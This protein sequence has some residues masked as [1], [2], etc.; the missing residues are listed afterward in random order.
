MQAK[1]KL[2]ALL[3]SL[4]MLLG[5]LPMT[6]FAAGVPAAPTNLKL[7]VTADGLKVSWDKPASTGGLDIFE[8]EVTLYGHFD[9]IAGG[10]TKVETKTV[11]RETTCTFTNTG[12]AEGV[13]NPNYEVEVKA[14]EG[15]SGTG[16][17]DNLGNYQVTDWTDWSNASTVSLDW[18]EVTFNTTINNYYTGVVDVG[19]P[20]SEN[21]LYKEGITATGNPDVTQPDGTTSDSEERAVTEL[22]YQYFEENKQTVPDLENVTVDDLTVEAVLDRFESSQEGDGNSWT[23]TI[24]ATVNRY[25]TLRLVYNPEADSNNPDEKQ[26]VNAVNLVNVSISMEMGLTPAFTAEVDSSDQDKY[27]VYL[28]QWIGSDG[29]SITSE[30]SFNSE[31]SEDE[32][33]TTFE[34]G[35]TYRYSVWVKAKEGYAISEEAS[36]YLNGRPANKGYTLTNHDEPKRPD[37]SFLSGTFNSLFVME[38]VFDQLKVNGIEVT[39]ANKDD[40]LGDADGLGATVSYDPDTN[41]LTLNNATLTVSEGFAAIHALIPNLTIVLKGE[42]QINGSGSTENGIYSNGNLTITG[43]GILK[44]EGTGFGLYGNTTI[45]ITGGADVNI[46]V[47]FS[48]ANAPQPYSAVRALRGLTVDGADLTAW[49]KGENGTVYGAPG[50]SASLT[51]KNGADVRIVSTNYDA[52]PHS[53]AAS[54]EGTK[55]LAFSE[56]SDHYG[57]GADGVEGTITISDGATVTARGGKGAMKSK[58]D[59]TGYTNPY[60]KAGAYTDSATEVTDPANTDYHMNTF[61]EI[62]AGE[63]PI[64]SF[65]YEINGESVT[66]TGYTGSEENVTIPSEI[67]GKPV[68]AIGERAFSHNNTLTS[69]AIPDSV[70]SIGVKAFYNCKSLG[71]VT[72]AGGSQLA[73]IGEEAFYGT[74]LLTSIEIPDGVT[75]IGKSAFYESGLENINIPAGVTTIGMGA[76]EECFNLSGVTFEKDSK[77]TEIESGTFFGCGKLTSIEIPAGV[78]SIGIMAFYFCSDLTS[79]TFEEGSQ[80]SSIRENAFQWCTGLTDITIPDGVTSIR[81]RA[82]YGCE[83]LGSITFTGNTA[84][85]L[86]ADDV[87]GKCAALTAIHV[88]CGADGYTAANGWPEDKVQKSEHRMDRHLR[89]PATCTTDGTIEHWRCALC[90]GYFL[91][92]AGTKEISEEQIVEKA[93][94]HDWGEPVWNWSDDG[95]TATVT[96][97]CKRDEKH[98]AEPDVTVTQEVKT[99]ATC[100][101]KGVA[102]DTAKAVLDGKEYTSINEN[103]AVEI[104][105]L[106]HKA[107]KVEGKAPT[108]TEPGNIEYWYCP[109]CDTYFKDAGLTEVITKEQTV[110]APT[111]ETKPEPSKPDE[112]PAAPTDPPQDKP[113]KTDDTTESPQT[114]DGSDMALWIGLMMASC[115]G[116]LGMLFYR[117]KKAA[118]GK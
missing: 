5:M 33:I 45:T 29:K 76:F 63:T 4:C 32:R 51:A 114:G 15:V 101:E 42:N 16:D 2:T 20:D 77:L 17:P 72:F 22:L 24:N 64:D 19:L 34:E 66:I 117:R 36:V 102:V 104:A 18:N 3:L 90:G 96:F 23:P 88:P 46:I 105:A 111:G 49:N 54:G 73:S 100:T 65:T 26:I 67:D 57:I 103:S 113:D 11:Q 1:R 86:E 44:T 37:G 62:K 118:A 84:P 60:I 95:K 9:G 91:D 6:A 97:T 12:N 21:K 8:Y 58:P 13:I 71:S 52:I 92:E 99:P 14:R 25:Y 94:G 68:T 115:G 93:T 55:V 107:E 82:F 10:K 108:A 112:T 40:I 83:K 80:L 87:F 61:V 50:I 69:V 48:S 110:L 56:S 89:V 38:C 116:V 78:T 43:D 53:L 85:E 98:T 79:V 28:E 31:I 74:E 109:Q 39:S 41:T 70:T 59:L 81:S 30:E 35:V 75:G 47:D 7:E 106:G 27:E